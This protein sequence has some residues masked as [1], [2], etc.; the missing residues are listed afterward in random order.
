MTKLTI[1]LTILF[2]STMNCSVA[3]SSQKP[4]A[5]VSRISFVLK[6]HAQEPH[7]DRIARGRK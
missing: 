4:A 2:V 6:H 1:A 5:K 3:Y 7:K